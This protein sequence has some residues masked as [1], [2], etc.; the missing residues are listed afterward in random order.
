MITLDNGTSIKKLTDFG[1]RELTEHE[2]P[3]QPA[4]ERKNVVIPGKAGTWNFGTQIGE[5][6]M[7]IPVKYIYTTEAEFQKKLNEFNSY[8]YDEIGEPVSL[9]LVY[10]YEKDKFFTVTIAENFI[11]DR[12]TILKS[13]VI[14][15]VANEPMKFAKSDEYDPV[16]NVVFGEVESGDFYHN[17]QEFNWVYSKHYSGVYNHSSLNTKFNIEIIGTIKNASVTHLDTGT[18]LTLPNVNNGILIVDANSFNIEV[19]GNSDVIGTNFNFFD[20]VPGRNGFL[21]ESEKP[22]AKVTFKWLHKFL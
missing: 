19:N 2:N 1:F 16:D 13:F 8:F 10:D 3:A 7:R 14:P 5:R 15:F 4:F 9:K 18:K 22:N 6:I 12:Q 20:L 11:P 21:F 17:T